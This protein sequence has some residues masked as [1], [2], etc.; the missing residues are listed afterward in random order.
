MGHDLTLTGAVFDAANGKFAQSLTGGYGVATGPV[1]TTGVFT[2]EAW[3][4]T[5]ASGT[6]VAAGQNYTAWIGTLGGNTAHARYGNQ[7]AGSEQDLLTSVIINDGVWHHLALVVG[8]AGGT[9][10]VD[11]SSAATSAVPIGS[12]GGYGSNV[13]FSVREFGGAIGAGFAWPGEVDEVALWTTAQYAGNFVPSGPIANSATGL[14][15]LWHLDGNG[16]DSAGAP[17][18]GLAVNTP[19]VVTAAQ[20]MSVSGSY[21]GVAPTGLNIQFDNAGFANVVSPTIAGGNFSFTTTAP[22]AGMHTLTVQESNVPSVVGVSGTFQS[23]TQ[24]T[25]TVS[26]PVG[27]VAGATMTVAG[28]YTGT[29]PSGLLFAFDGGAYGAALAPNIAAGQFSFTTAAPAL[30]SHTVS[31]QESNAT[32]VSGTSAAF[33]ASAAPTVILPSHSALLYSPYNWNIM[34]SSAI[35]VNAGATLRTM[36][37]GTTCTLHFDISHNAMPLSELWFRIDGIGPWTMAP[38]ASSISCPLPQGT[39]GNAD[40]PYHGLELMVKSTTETQNRWNVPSATAVSFSGLTLDAG[41]VVLAPVAKPAS[42]LIYGDSITEGVRTVGETAANDTDRNDAMAGWACHLGDLMGAEIGVVG[43]GGSGLSVIGSGNVPALPSSYG[44]IYQ[45]VARVFAPVPTMVVFNIGTNDGSANIVAAMVSVLDGIL[46]SCPGAL[47]VVLRPFN[48]NQ[49][50]NLQAAIAACSAPASCHFVDTTGV[51]DPTK[52]SDSLALHPNAV[53]NLGFILPRLAA[54][55]RPLLSP[56][57]APLFRSG[58]TLG[59]LS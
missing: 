22:A 18:A 12:A 34:P 38:V 55:L 39:A 57:V 5:T 26:T 10:Y 15:A 4:K 48:G 3:V 46:L 14:A 36:F 27:V 6:Y 20:P 52:G 51:F 24:A 8:T 59:L 17:A 1:P 25:L 50:S 45:G 35:T 31:V 30:G 42:V 41:A 56:S 44:E 54:L 58:M 43:F 28:S 9:L 19:G 37:T 40:F 21:T 47:I 7:Q 32:S 2:L 53:N 33:T 23:T 16:A 49:A 13:Q 11:G 29:P